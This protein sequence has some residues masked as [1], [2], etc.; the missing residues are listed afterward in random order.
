[1]IVLQRLKGWEQRLVREHMSAMRRLWA[2]GA[3]DCAIFAANSILVVTGEDMAA[4]FR[5]QYETEAEAW[6]FLARLGYADLGALASSR[7]PEI[8]PRDARRADVVL[9]PGELGDYLSICDGRTAVGPVARGIAHSPMGMAK[10]A[11]R[12]G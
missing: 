10:R 1:M 2:W 7:L 3:H 9:M 11:W 4:D 12:V 6:D 5:G 8:E